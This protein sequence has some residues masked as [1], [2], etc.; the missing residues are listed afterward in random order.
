MNAK[1][2]SESGLPSNVQVVTIGGV[3]GCST[4]YHLTKPGWT[5]IV[6]LERKQLIW[7]CLPAAHVHV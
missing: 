3:I 7:N 2:D 1:H 5:D 6:I 4:A